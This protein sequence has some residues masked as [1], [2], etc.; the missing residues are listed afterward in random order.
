M[1]S[2]NVTMVNPMKR[3]IKPPTLEMASMIDVSSSTPM[4]W[5][6]G[7]LRKLVTN[8]AFSLA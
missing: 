1:T 7:V 8:A 6:N 2:A 4:I 5:V 3:P